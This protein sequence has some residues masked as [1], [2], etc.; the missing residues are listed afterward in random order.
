MFFNYI[1]LFFS[2]DLLFRVIY[3]VIKVT[4]SALEEEALGLNLPS[5]FPLI[6]PASAAVATYGFAHIES[7]LHHQ[8]PV[9]T[10]D[11]LQDPAHEQS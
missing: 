3:S 4:T 7:D 10:L 6:K 9:L 5:P 11:L 1:I 8:T 2:C